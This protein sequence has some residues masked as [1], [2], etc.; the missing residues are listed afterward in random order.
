MVG[1]AVTPHV[2]YRPCFPTVKFSA[3]ASRHSYMIALCVHLQLSVCGFLFFTS[4]IIHVRY[5]PIFV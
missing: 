3:V 1:N 2:D 5:W 4:I